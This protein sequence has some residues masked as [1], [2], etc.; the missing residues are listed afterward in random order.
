ME[1]I[2]EC[3][4]IGR[5]ENL[6]ACII[7]D[8]RNGVAEWTPDGSIDGAAL[9]VDGANPSIARDK[10]AIDGSVDSAAPSTDCCAIDGSI[11]GAAP[12]VDGAD[13]SIARDKC[14]DRRCCHVRTC[15][16]LTSNDWS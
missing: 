13:P 3:R 4:L 2:T 12:S 6:V 10:C 16:S 14:T 1:D 11:D 7:V 5:R 9:S 8:A 15:R